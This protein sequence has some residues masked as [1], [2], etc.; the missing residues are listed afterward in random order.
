MY[1]ANKYT[2]CYTR[3]ITRAQERSQLNGYSE[4]HHIIPKSLGGSNKKENLVKLTAKEHFICHLLLTKMTN[5]NSMIFAAWKMANQNNKFQERYKV[6]AKT[7]ATLREQFANAKRNCPPSDGARKKNS[8]SHKG[9]RWSTGMTDKKHSI[10]TIEKMRLAREKQVI[11]NE[12]K[13]KLSIHMTKIASSPTYINPMDRDG[14]KERHKAA[15]L[16]R[17]SKKKECPHC[18]GQFTANSFARYHGDKCK[19]NAYRFSSSQ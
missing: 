13:K 8:D 15:C 1:L 10:E 14:V 6:N 16:L 4:M 2:A 11:T 19:R 3:I 12:T 7:Y 9:I 18:G 5:S 17:S